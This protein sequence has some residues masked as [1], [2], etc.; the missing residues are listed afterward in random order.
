M[1]RDVLL[2]LLVLALLLNLA[3]LS[4]V[5]AMRARRE[6][7]SARDRDEAWRREA[8]RRAEVSRTMSP[9]LAP[10]GTARTFFVPARDGNGSS[11]VALSEGSPATNHDVAAAAMAETRAIA[12][13]PATTALAEPTPPIADDAPS[14]DEPHVA[15]QP[16]LDAAA[17]TTPSDGG[18]R[19]TR[20]RRF[21]LPKLDEDQDR[22]SEAIE[23][24]L[25]GPPPE[26]GTTTERPQRRRHRV[27]RPAGTPVPRTTL[28]VW[29]QGF[30]DLDRAVGTSRANHVS[31]AFRDALR[32]SARATDEVRE[33]GS[34]RVRL[35]IDADDA[36]ANA[37]VERAR[38]S[39]QPWL[40]L[41][42]VPLRVESGAHQSTQVIPFAGTR[43]AV[44]DR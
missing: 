25:D 39:V 26:P 23:A 29:L 6:R 24:F 41:L 14:A 35:I 1:S 3:F 2:A 33:A 18:A 34:G 37:Y 44:V 10:G 13:L 28:L 32:R 9:Q 8:A 21:V 11:R 16:S 22:T 19:K 31:N 4:Q 15:A 5:G 20:G 40:E 27:R 30:A 17:V 43:R 7:S 42:S 12:A 38:A 36:G